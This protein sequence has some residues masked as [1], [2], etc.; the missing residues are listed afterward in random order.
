LV[1]SSRLPRCDKMPLASLQMQSSRG[2]Q[3]WARSPLPQL[4]ATR[5]SRESTLI[6]VLVPKRTGP[7]Q[8][9]QWRMYPPRTRKVTRLGM[10]MSACLT[11]PRFFKA[12]FKVF[13]TFS[14]MSPRKVVS[15]LLH[16][17]CTFAVL[18]HVLHRSAVSSLDLCPMILPSA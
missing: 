17:T 5:H 14:Q 13:V 10:T 6:N 8:G 3:S 11:T 15:T 2:L 12:T 4:Q 18:S 9:R 1:N 16:A 7:F